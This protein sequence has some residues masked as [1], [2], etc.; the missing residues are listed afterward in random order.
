[1]LNAGCQL[2]TVQDART[3]WND[4]QGIKVDVKLKKNSERKW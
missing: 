3:K 2:V 4:E 1:M